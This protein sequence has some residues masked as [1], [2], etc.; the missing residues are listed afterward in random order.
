[1]LLLRILYASY[2]SLYVQT[3]VGLTEEIANFDVPSGSRKVNGKY[4]QSHLLS[5]LE[6]NLLERATAGMIEALHHYILH[7]YFSAETLEIIT[8]AHFA[9]F[10]LK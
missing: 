10:S 4:I 6:G 1:M 2:L 8:M 9:N 3:L 5:R 7:Y